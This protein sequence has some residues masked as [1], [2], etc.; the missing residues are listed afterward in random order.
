MTTRNAWG[1]WGHLEWGLGQGGILT[2]GHGRAW[3]EQDLPLLLFLGLFYF[4]QLGLDH[5]GQE[6]DGGGAKD[7]PGQVPAGA[8][9]PLGSGHRSL[10]H[11]DRTS[12]HALR[13]H[14][15][16]ADQSLD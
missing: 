14:L 15:G 12:G 5:H 7:D 4:Q 1:G 10:G 16:K 9:Q 11:A 8:V 13:E 2:G 6:E 3:P